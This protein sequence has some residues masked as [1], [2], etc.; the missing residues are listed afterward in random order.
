M[1]F[2]RE[3]NVGFL[4]ETSAS[5]S[6]GAY[7]IQISGLLLE[8]TVSKAWGSRPRSPVIGTLK[9]EIY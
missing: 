6:R 1:E 3:F 4:H 7:E 2:L 8:P 5:E 9:F